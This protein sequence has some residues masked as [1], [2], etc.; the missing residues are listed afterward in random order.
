MSQA[1]ATSTDYEF[2]YTDKLRRR[3]THRVRTFQNHS[4]TTI[5]ITDLSHQFICPS[6]TN[7]IEDLVNDLLRER[8]DIR[9]DRMVVIEHY[10]HRHQGALSGYGKSFPEEQETYDLVSFQ[11]SPDRKLLEPDWKRITKAQAEE[12]I[13][14]SLM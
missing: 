2:S 5:L 3:A 10:D 9:R 14:C 6:V 4:W 1:D 8:V 11:V 7:S 12:W 13:G